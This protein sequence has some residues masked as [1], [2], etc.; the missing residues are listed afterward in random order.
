MPTTF[1][2]VLEL[3]HNNKNASLLHENYGAYY[4]DGDPEGNGNP[5]GFHEFKCFVSELLTRVQPGRTKFAKAK[6]HK[7]V[8]ECFTVS[9]E[10]FALMVI[11]NELHAWDE[12]IAMSNSKLRVKKKYT[13][14]HGK[15]KSTHCGWSKRGIKIYRQL[16]E[17][18]KRQRQRQERHANERWFREEFRKDVGLGPA[19]VVGPDKGATTSD[20][21]DSESDIEFG[22]E[23][24]LEDY[25]MGV[26]GM[27]QNI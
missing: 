24:A 1:P 26:N 20:D 12:Q 4:P 7:C 10:A 13:D 8:S 2:G 27:M 3:Q 5:E 21:S 14:G 18:V 11:D 25:Y 9:D 16:E 17:E 23:G 19:V 15:K 6:T 22:E